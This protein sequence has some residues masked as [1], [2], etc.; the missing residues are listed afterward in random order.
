MGHFI[1]PAEVAERLPPDAAA[2]MPA[3]KEGI[4]DGQTVQHLEKSIHVQAAMV[5]YDAR[6]HERE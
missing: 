6:D 4:A 3:S 5:P 2:P 1:E